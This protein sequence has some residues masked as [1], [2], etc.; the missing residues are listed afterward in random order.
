MTQSDLDNPN[1]G[2]RAGTDC[3]GEQESGR[4]TK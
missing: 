2:D 4:Q 3:L 1:Q